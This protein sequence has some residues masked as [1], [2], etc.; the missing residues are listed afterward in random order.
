M[1]LSAGIVGIVAAGAAAAAQAQD[2][3]Q[4]PGFT[5]PQA[6]RGA[7]LYSGA[8]AVC[9]GDGLDDGQFG[10]PLKGPP[11]SAYWSGKTAEDVLVYMASNMP[12]TQPGALGAQAYADIMAYMLQADGG[13]PGDKELPADPAASRGAAPTR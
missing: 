4:A 12:P 13:A 5:A 10:P 9:H 11:H 7:E 8:C 3:R 6:K 2:A 1:M